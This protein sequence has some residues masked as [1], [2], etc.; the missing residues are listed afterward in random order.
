[1]E[2]LDIYGLSFPFW[3]VGG[4][5]NIIRRI[6]EKLGGSSLTSNMRDFDGFIRD[7]EL[8]DPPLRNVPFT[9]SNLQ[10]SPV[11]K[12]LDR[13]LYTNEWE[14]FFPQ[15]LQEVLPKWTSDHCPLFWTPFHSSGGQ[16]LLGLRI[17]GCNILVSKIAL[18]V[19]GEAFREL[20]G[21]VISLWGIY[22]LL[23]PNWKSGI[24]NLL[25]C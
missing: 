13:F 21:K 4:D 2:L 23:R 24:R 22:N 17:R 14:H 6:S 18:E 7:C 20:V 5:F 16:L 25:E 10:D 8:I 15:N 12:R 11:C 19:G 1:M 9:W 3:C